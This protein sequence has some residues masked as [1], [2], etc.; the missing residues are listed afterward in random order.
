AE[1]PPDIPNGNTS[2]EGVLSGA[3]ERIEPVVSYEHAR[4][5]DAELLRACP[6]EFTQPHDGLS[7]THC[8]RI[9]KRGAGALSPDT[10]PRDFGTS[11]LTILQETSSAEYP[12]TSSAGTVS[13]TG[14]DKPSSTERRSLTSPI[15][16]D[17]GVSRAS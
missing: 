3:A 7:S 6:L 5:V 13:G 4:I 12:C 9:T 11:R 8:R 15:M 10:P 16:T 17:R 14:T 2:I 1:R